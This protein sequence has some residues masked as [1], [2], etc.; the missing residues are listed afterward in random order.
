MI[1]DNPRNNRSDLGDR[2]QMDL[3]TGE[4][5]FE[6]DTQSRQRR[7]GLHMERLLIQS[8]AGGHRPAKLEKAMAFSMIE[9]MQHNG[10]VA[11]KHLRF[12]IEN[13]LK[14]FNGVDERLQHHLRPRRLG[15]GVMASQYGARV[16]PRRRST[17]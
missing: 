13:A 5:A 17:A 8:A 12:L 14:P 16:A 4:I 11:A 3:Q 7:L 1:L 10:P 6:L 9:I 15:D 2:R